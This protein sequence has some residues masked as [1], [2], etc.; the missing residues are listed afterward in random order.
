MPNP[1]LILVLFAQAPGT[2]EATSPDA[3]GDLASLVTDAFAGRSCSAVGA[4]RGCLDQRLSLETAAT[5]ATTEDAG[6][7]G[8]ALA[9]VQCDFY[10]DH[11]EAAGVRQLQ[12][13]EDCRWLAG[14]LSARAELKQALERE[15]ATAEQLAKACTDMARRVAEQRAA[16]IADASRA[17]ADAELATFL[18]GHPEVP[19]QAISAV[20][21]RTETYRQWVLGQSKKAGRGASSSDLV[22]HRVAPSDLQQLTDFLEGKERA[23]RRVLQE[24]FQHRPL[25]CGNRVVKLLSGCVAPPTLLDNEE[26]ELA[27]DPEQACGYE[28]ADLERYTARGWYL[29]ADWFQPTKI[30]SL[31]N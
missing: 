26:D 17:S 1:A 29:G 15:R 19:I 21:C 16:K 23:A 13:L 22:P 3:C 5:D 11:P 30:G 27:K 7:T 31:K 8:D 9:K 28:S 24:R 14:Q 2:G 6:P 20:L 4:I 25:S 10:Q 18:R 12:I